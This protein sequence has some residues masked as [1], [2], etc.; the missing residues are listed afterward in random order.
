MPAEDNTNDEYVRKRVEDISKLIYEVAAG[1]FDYKLKQRDVEGE[2]E[3]LIGGINMLGEELKAS[4]VSRDFME[5]IYKGVVDILIII[6]PDQTIDRVN[7]AVVD[8]LGYS[9]QDLI[10]RDFK[11][12]LSPG[13]FAILEEIKLHLNS[14]GAYH[15]AEL[16]LL[17]KDKTL[18]ETSASFS[19]LFDNQKNHLGTIVI[20]KDITHIKT[21]ERELKMA[22]E[23]AEAANKAKSH[24]L[25]NMSHEIRTP[26]NGMLGF[27]ELLGGTSLDPD[28]T[29]YLDM[30]KTSGQSLAKLLNDILD[31]SK[32]ENGK[33]N[34]EYVPFNLKN[35]LQPSFQTYSY[36]AREKGLDFVF[37]FTPDLPELVIGDP[38]RLTQILSNLIGNSLK[39]TQEGGLFIRLSGNKK[40]NRRLNLLLEVTDTGVGIPDQMQ[41]SI[42]DSFTQADT[43]TTRKYGGA[44]LGLAITK[45]L[46]ALMNGT[47]RFECPPVS[48]GRENGTSFFVEL[49]LEMPTSSERPES[50]PV[51]TKQT[52]A[53]PNG[54][55]VLLVDDNE[56]NILLAQKVLEK[57]NAGVSLARDGKQALD[58][59]LERSF[60]VILMDI[61]MPVMDGFE[62]STAL[63]KAGYQAPII[64]LSANVYPEEI[65]TCFENGMNGHIGKPFTLDGIYNKITSVV[66]Q[67]ED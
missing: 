37:E 11:T 33:L 63:R 47:I 12:L 61:Q 10:A 57:L 34:I 43:S 46:V 15:N 9:P 16:R 41:T 25:A 23:K 19:S 44:G 3:G 54:F 4:T 38:S 20:A 29:E 60:D 42:F 48:R 35:T 53:F 31:L 27:L 64:A 26:L 17:R 5:S 65:K 45:H 55:R 50:D 58:L 7:D 51:T 67:T 52:L 1:N 22:K 8:H 56:I 13:D 66:N 40:D 6:N 62:A 30:I 2:L 24:F 32:V 21:T 39:F 36:L 59:A 28:Q 14:N 49:P 18:L